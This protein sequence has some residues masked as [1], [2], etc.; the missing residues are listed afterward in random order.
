MTFRISCVHNVV[1][2]VLLVF[3]IGCTS[4]LHIGRDGPGESLNGTTTPAHS[5]MDV[6]ITALEARPEHVLFDVLL[7]TSSSTP[8]ALDSWQ[9]AQMLSNITFRD[10]GGEVWQIRDVRPT[11]ASGGRP[12]QEVLTASC[13]AGIN[14]S[15][16]VML[17]GILVPLTRDRSYAVLPKL[18]GVDQ[19]SGEVEAFISGTPAGRATCNVPGRPY[20]AIV[21]RTSGWEVFENHE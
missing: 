19:L 13:V 16:R 1:V 20:G 15:D 6:L 3:S 5:G 4:A 7:H 9:L 18:F 8:L 11:G 21:V 2:T 10:A 12:P 14:A 17:R